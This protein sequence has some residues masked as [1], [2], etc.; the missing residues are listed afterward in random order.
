MRNERRELGM[1]ATAIALGV[2]VLAVAGTMIA[3]SCYPTIQKGPIAIYEDALSAGWN[4]SSN[5]TPVSAPGGQ[6][7]S[8]AMRVDFAGANSTAELRWIN[9]A[10]D[11]T[12]NGYL[13]FRIRKEDANG[14]IYVTGRKADG[15]L[16]DALPSLSSYLVWGL[17]TVFVPQQWY[18][19]RVPLADMGI[20]PGTPLQSVVFESATQTTIYL[21]EIVLI[22][23]LQVT[24]PLQY[25]GWTPYTATIASIFD[26]NMTATYLKN[27]NI[28]VTTAWT[29]ETGDGTQDPGD[30]TCREKLV[31]DPYGPT[32]FVNGHY[33]SGCFDTPAGNTYLSYN[34]HAGIDY[35]VPM[36]TVV[37]AAA[38]GVIVVIDCTSKTFGSCSGPNQGSGFGRIVVQHPNGYATWYM[39]LDAQYGDPNGNP[40]V[41]GSSVSQGQPIGYSGKTDAAQAVGPHLHFQITTGPK[42]TDMPIDPYGWDGWYADPYHA[43]HQTVFNSRQ[44]Q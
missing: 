13:W 7:G 8:Y 35:P 44:W 20:E 23:G 9:A 4:A 12:H 40:L 11:T 41:F 15:T 14:G 26:H 43:N 34:G 21:D 3:Q 30:S 24:F 42:L 33:Q 32:F 36:D 38:T 37:Y 2:T 28:N 22:D 29:G 39:H 25:N 27:A 5:I 1:M 19:V 31:S 18:S 10:F 6:Y 16:G 17:S